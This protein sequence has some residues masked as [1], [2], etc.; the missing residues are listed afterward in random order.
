MADGFRA[1]RFA[2]LPGLVTM[3]NSIGDDDG[4]CRLLGVSSRTLA[5]WRKSGRVPRAV[6]LALFWETPWGASIADCDAI[7]DARIQFSR[8]R[9]LERE[10]AVLR[11]QVSRL[12]LELMRSGSVAA[13]A[14]FYRVGLG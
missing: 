1:P 2:Q 5:R 11:A 14:P 10:N 7:N 12:E 8:A 3:L 9:V 13:N 6:M 4:V